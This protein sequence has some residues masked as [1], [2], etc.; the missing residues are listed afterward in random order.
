[1]YD[2]PIKNLSVKH[3]KN[4]NLIKTLDSPLTEKGRTLYSLSHTNCNKTVRVIRNHNDSWNNGSGKSIRMYG[5]KEWLRIHSTL[6][7]TYCCTEKEETKTQ[8]VLLTTEQNIRYVFPLE[9][10]FLCSL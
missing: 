6:A 5:A 4:M 9:I 8:N 2:Q 7:N 1:M 3:K 10:L